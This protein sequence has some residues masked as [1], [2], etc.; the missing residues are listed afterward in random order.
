MKHYLL[1]ATLFLCALTANAQE[2]V[3]FRHLDVSANIG[4]TGIGFEVST[5]LSNIVRLRAGFDAMHRFDTNINFPVSGIK[6]DGS[7]ISPSTFQ[8][9][10]EM[11]EKFTS[12][13]VKDNVNMVC[14]PKM[15]NFRLLVDVY[16]FKKINSKF[17]KKLYFTG[18]FYWGPSKIATAV[19][20]TEDATTLLAVN[21]YNL[22][23]DRFT[24]PI[25][26]YG[27]VYYDVNEFLG[28]AMLDPKAIKK[29][30][31]KLEQYGHMGMPL[32]KYAHDVYDASGN[33]VHKAGETYIMYPDENG[34]V[35]AEMT[36][37]S[38]KPYV[39]IGWGTDLGCKWTFSVDLGVLFWGGSPKLITH[40]GTDLTNDV[41]DVRGKVGDYV[42][43]AKK[44]KVFPGLNFKISKTIF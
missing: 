7:E 44:F 2:R 16:P 11:A 5:P 27:Q 35:S 20:A 37:N 13:K 31:E 26:E 9:M 4:T 24:V 33:V 15:L 10:A 38:F 8:Q 23:Y 19:N 41:T 30:R 22:Q 18:G 40:D 36:V 21:S 25:N 43:A 42:S 34:M 32:G 1:S 12:L 28:V 6:S 3:A 17:L 39:G 29:V 14:T